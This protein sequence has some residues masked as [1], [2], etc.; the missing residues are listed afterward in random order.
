M[1]WLSKG[2]IEYLFFLSY[3]SVLCVSGFKLKKNKIK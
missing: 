2:K 3:G 1:L